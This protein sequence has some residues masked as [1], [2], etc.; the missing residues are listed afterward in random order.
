MTGHVRFTSL[1]IAALGSWI[2]AGSI[3]TVSLCT[4]E[5][6]GVFFWVTSLVVLGIEIALMMPL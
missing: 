1:D 5:M 6:G 4:F 2:I 3:D